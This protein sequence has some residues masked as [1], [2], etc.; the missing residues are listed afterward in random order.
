VADPESAPL[1]ASSVV[2]VPPGI[3]HLDAIV[4]ATGAADGDK[5]LKPVHQLQRWAVEG[6]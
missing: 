5:R 1:A 4:K 2:A 6:V 3:E